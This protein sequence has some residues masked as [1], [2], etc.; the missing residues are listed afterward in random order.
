MIVKGKKIRRWFTELHSS[1]SLTEEFACQIQKLIGWLWKLNCRLP[2]WNYFLCLFNVLDISEFTSD[3][4]KEISGEPQRVWFENQTRYKICVSM[5]NDLSLTWPTAC[6]TKLDS[7]DTY[8]IDSTYSRW[9]NI[10]ILQY[11]C[12]LQRRQSFEVQ[13]KRKTK[14][15]STT[16]R[17]CILK[18]DVNTLNCGKL[19]PRHCRR[20]SIASIIF[21]IIYV[22][23]TSTSPPFRF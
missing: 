17:R 1:E 20:R 2:D 13:L 7:R 9:N 19:C 10:I 23:W 5:F 15:W 6:K 8:W 4:F 21:K 22:S 14:S 18:F 12:W 16:R 3:H 11:D